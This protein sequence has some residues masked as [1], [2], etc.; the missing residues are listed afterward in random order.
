MKIKMQ[1]GLGWL[2]IA[3]LSGACSD[4]FTESKQA[5]E[6]PAAD[7]YAA[8]ELSVKL[9]KDI[10]AQLDGTQRELTIPTG[11]H[12]LDEYMRAQGAVRLTRIFPYAGKDEALQQREG[13]DLWYT[14]QLSK[15]PESMTRAVGDAARGD[16]A[17]FVEP[18]FAAKLEK[19][20]FQAVDMAPTRDNGGPSRFDDP[21]YSRQW[22]FNN[23]GNI[24]NYTDEKGN[25]VVSSIVGA[26][27]NVEPAWTITTGK[28]EVVVAVVDGGVDTGHPD[29][30]GS[31]WTNKGEI[32]GN[33]LDDDN[34]GYV[35]DYYGYNFADDKG[36]V[37]PTRHG[38]H[39]A[40]TIAARNNNGRGVCGI[41]GGDGTADSGTRIMCCQI[42]KDNPNYDPTD[43]ESTETIGTGNRNLDA[44]AIVYGANNGAVIS[45]NSWGYGAGS[46]AT[47]Q[48]V[49]E[50]IAYFNKYA[51][52]DK[53]EKPVMQG[54]LV[55]FAAGNDGLR[56]ST[57]P[58]ADDD[59]VSVAAF[60]PDFQASW[61]TNYGETVDL[62][63]P[64]GSQPVKEKYPRENGLPTSA[65]LS[66]V[67]PNAEG[68]N[69]YAYMQG[70]S[71]A[72]P[73]VSGIAA[74]VVSKYGGAAF[75]AAELRR[76]LL[77]GVKQ[78]NYNEYVSA[79]HF[80]GMGLGYVD[81]MEALADYDMTVEPVAPQ[82]L[83]EKSKSGYNSVTIAWK[84]ANKG[85]DGSLQNYI[86]YMSEQ[87]ITQA[88]CGQAT[89]HLINANYA[90][91]DEVFERT[92]MRMAANTT[93]Y[94]AIQAVARNGKTSPLVILQNGVTTLYNEAPTIAVSMDGNR[95][96]LAGRDKADVV[97]TITDKENHKCSYQFRD[98]GSVGI[99]TQDNKVMLHVEA[100]NYIPGIYPLT[101]TVK[102]EYGASSSFTL[103]IEIV[104]DKT[105]TLKA[106]F[107]TLN[108]KR[109]QHKTVAL[110]DWI[111]DE[112]PDGL[113]Y[114]TKH[115][116]SVEVKVADGEMTITGKR[117]G[118]STIEL[119]ATDVHGQ[120]GV[121]SIPVFVYEKEGIYAV[122]PTIATTTLYMK[123]GEEVEGD[124]EVVVRSMAGK[125][126][127]RKRF[128]VAALD[129][130][131]RT[132][133]MD[134]SGIA[135]GSYVVSL[136][137]RGVV[138]Q[139]KFVKK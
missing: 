44:A 123:V 12:R 106:G 18:V 43:P 135:R 27:I 30:Q 88:N 119:S 78:M 134:V 111:V 21:L 101:L 50:A 136:V 55:I 116:G 77:A 11:S 85:S 127:L 10:V 15:A 29:L 24:G 137:N 114:E 23:R 28:R 109:G 129:R 87:P 74:L 58:A 4:A 90:K 63:A 22:D 33:G 94:F 1:S 139:D 16:V 57:Y 81:A 34:N 2:L 69:G 104:A 79:N 122:Y 20:S 42:F 3:L 82:F 52:G 45:Q 53:T 110:K 47:P 97:F 36:V 59:V 86:L 60:N 89:R 54:G 32:P 112:K 120:T 39:V 102:D 107:E 92:N 93:C 48:V 14:M 13:L 19:V 51:G 26:D 38:T 67:P 7:G 131:K 9:H 25:P 118:E 68:K 95:L 35:D 6:T 113:V 100:T 84:S 31:F 40:G 115:D 37:T 62:A 99:T 121:F 128:S 66:T 91:A 46:K 103:F 71:M 72:C 125:E 83:P 126:V 5:V 117:F 75:T 64:G 70:T 65:V 8:Q 49:K 133:L 124:A 108:I 73:H 41:A 132:L 17:T 138:Y 98:A 80:D 105:P 56:S 76:R 96:T 130:Q 61:Y